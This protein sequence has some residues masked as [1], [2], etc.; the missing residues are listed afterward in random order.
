M[1]LIEDWQEE[2]MT[3]DSARMQRQN[4]AE[5]TAIAGSCPGEAADYEVQF[6]L[7][8]KRI[9]RELFRMREE[10]G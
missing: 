3:I 10:N 4:E 6:I 8:K 5:L 9:R 7:K 1:H 2:R